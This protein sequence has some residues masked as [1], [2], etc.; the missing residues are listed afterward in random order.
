MLKTRLI[1]C[2]AAVIMTPELVQRK[3]QWAKEQDNRQ[4]HVLSVN[5]SLENERKIQFEK[6]I[7]N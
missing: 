2:F 5:T 4:F 3:L 7:R 6:N 1:A